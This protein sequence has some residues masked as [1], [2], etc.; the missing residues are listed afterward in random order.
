MNTRLT[1][2]E[3]KQEL[4]KRGM[5]QRD[6]VSWCTKNKI[7]NMST[8]LG[9]QNNIFSVFCSISVHYIL[10]LIDKGEDL[11]VE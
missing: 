5:I 9:E 10:E 1:R 2:D 4:A 8:K 3:F 6:F 11:T 7:Y